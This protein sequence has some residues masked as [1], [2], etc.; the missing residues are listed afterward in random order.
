MCEAAFCPCLSVQEMMHT[1]LLGKG[2]MEDKWDYSVIHSLLR[3]TTKKKGCS[4]HRHHFWVCP[5]LFLTICILTLSVMKEKANLS[6]VFMYASSPF[7]SNVILWI[8]KVIA[9]GLRLKE[10]CL[11]TMVEYFCIRSRLA[12]EKLKY[13][14]S[15]NPR[16]PPLW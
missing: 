3:G 14:K 13:S 12:E 6:Y 11:W 15:R 7:H 1:A 4:V 9:M 10:K 16:R 2:R 8:K 5:N